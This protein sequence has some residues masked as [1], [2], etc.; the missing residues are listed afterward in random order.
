[1]GIGDDWAAGVCAC[2]GPAASLVS[3]T[4]CATTRSA[5][6]TMVV[7]AN[8]IIPKLRSLSLNV[9]VEGVRVD[10]VAN[11]RPRVDRWRLARVQ[12]PGRTSS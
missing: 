8:A 12:L 7:T 5:P 9:R 1:M 11:P 10:N 6:K 3:V 2:G 4:P